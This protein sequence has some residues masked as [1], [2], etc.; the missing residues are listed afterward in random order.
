MNKE[1]FWENIHKSR[2]NAGR[3]DQQFLLGITDAL[4]KLDNSQLGEFKAIFNEYRE[5][6]YTPGLW[7]AAMIM[8]GLYCTSER[9]MDFRA[10]MISQGKEVYL[11]ALANPDSLA[12]I[13]TSGEYALEGFAYVCDDVYRN[14]TGEKFLPD[15]AVKLKTSEKEKI[16]AEIQYD[17]QINVI[18]TGKEIEEYIPCLCEKF[19]PNQN[20]ADNWLEWD[21]MSLSMFR[22]DTWKQSAA[23]SNMISDE[24]QDLILIADESLSK[25]KDILESLLKSSCDTPQEKNELTEAIQLIQKAHEKCQSVQAAMVPDHQEDI[26]MGMM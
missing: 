26:T 22:R 10:W 20:I 25:A 15:E 17:S 4:S 19:Q 7:D 12:A 6:A 1:N 23:F 16:Q 9:F 18:R 3:N 21:L 8:N 13:D 2:T 11:E 14:R 24:N 5:I